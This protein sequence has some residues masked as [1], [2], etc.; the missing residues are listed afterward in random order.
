MVRLISRS[1]LRVKVLQSPAKCSR[2]LRG[3]RLR[4]SIPALKKTLRLTNSLTI[5]LTPK[6]PP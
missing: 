1:Q 2:R 5:V 3:A 6:T 4:R